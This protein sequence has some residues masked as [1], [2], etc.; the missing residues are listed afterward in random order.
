MREDHSSSSRNY[1][2]TY[3]YL[4]TYIAKEYAPKRHISQT[5]L[6]FEEALLHTWMKDSSLS[7]YICTVPT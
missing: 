3:L 2:S 1:P 4:D 7:L 5:G 6:C